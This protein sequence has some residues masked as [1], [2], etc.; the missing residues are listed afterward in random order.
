MHPQKG[1]TTLFWAVSERYA[2]LAALL[3][4]RS[5]DTEAKDLVSRAGVLALLPELLYDPLVSDNLSTARGIGGP[6][7]GEL[8]RAVARGCGG[9][10]PDQHNRRMASQFT[11]HPVEM[12]ATAC[13]AML[14]DSN[15]GSAAA[16]SSCGH[17]ESGLELRSQCLELC[18][19]GQRLGSSLLQTLGRCSLLSTFPFSLSHARPQGAPLWAHVNRGARQG[20]HKMFATI[21]ILAPPPPSGRA[22]VRHACAA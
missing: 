8:P 2:E 6:L 4:D 11:L 16:S 18:F 19:R 12:S 15:V 20:P 22:F 21:I 7:F 17:I 13:S 1:R 3:L 10:I 14:G 9:S 5:A